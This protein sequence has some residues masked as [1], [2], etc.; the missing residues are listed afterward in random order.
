LVLK[1][2]QKERLL[3]SCK[4][5]IDKKNSKLTYSMFGSWFTIDPAK[6]I[7]DVFV[8]K[9]CCVDASSE[10]RGKNRRDAHCGEQQRKMNF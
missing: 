6:L 9:C 2:I 8:R 4:F 10:L 5:L 1:S 3:A 7:I